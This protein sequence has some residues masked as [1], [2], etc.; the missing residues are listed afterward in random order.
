MKNFVLI[1]FITAILSIGLTPL[2][3]AE[4]AFNCDEESLEQSNIAEPASDE[5]SFQDDYSS[6]QHPVC[7]DVK[8]P[9]TFYQTKRLSFS[10]ATDNYENVSSIDLPP[11]EHPI[12]RKYSKGASTY[13][14]I[15][16]GTIAT[17]YSG[18]AVF[19]FS[20]SLFLA[21]AIGSSIGVIAGFSFTYCAWKTLNYLFKS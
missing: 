4:A 20:S 3:T 9:N 11:T 16:L 6:E 14:G 18:V 12:E 8:T 1:F 15:L 17:L 10:Q 21:A 5:S 2:R 13:L 19:D 7:D